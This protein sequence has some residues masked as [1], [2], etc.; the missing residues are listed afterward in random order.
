MFKYKSNGKNLFKLIENKSFKRDLHSK[1]TNF[2]VSQN[3][4]V[5]IIPQWKDNYSY[6]YSSTLLPSSL[7]LFF[8][9]LY[10]I[11]TSS[12]LYSPLPFLSSNIIP[13]ALG[14]S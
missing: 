8:K 13:K 10:L 5:A 1:I 2:K 11:I 6:I 14:S 3:L 7:F 4:D 12:L 9:P